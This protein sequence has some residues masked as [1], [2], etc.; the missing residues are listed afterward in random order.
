[1]GGMDIAERRLPQDGRTTI[2]IMDKT[3]DIRI[4]SLP[5]VYGEKITMRLLVRS[6]EV[7]KLSELGFPPIQE[8]QYNGVIH[9]PYGFILVTGPTGSGKSTTLYAT[10][11]EI[12]SEDKNII[13]LEDPV[14]RRMY[15]ISQIQMNERAGMTFMPRR[16]YGAPA[17]R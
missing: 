3:I 10:L 15:G 13:T 2:K 8:E 9:L 7:I 1:M 4:A 11:A 17:C 16:A 12:N 6:P 14:E 5:S